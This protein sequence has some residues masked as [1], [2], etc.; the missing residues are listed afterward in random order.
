MRKHFPAMNDALFLRLKEVRQRYND[1]AAASQL[2]VLC[3]TAAQ[4]LDGPRDDVQE[5]RLAM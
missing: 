1:G 4:V 3:A 5:L 2:H